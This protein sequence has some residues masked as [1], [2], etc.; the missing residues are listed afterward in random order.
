MA[1]ATVL[2]S[3]PT[4]I[5]ISPAGLVTSTTFLAGR[6][7]TE[8]DNTTPKFLDAN[9][10]GFVTTG[11]TPTVGK[12]IAIY[13]WGAH[14]SLATTARDVLDGLDSAETITSENVRAGFLKLAVAVQVDAASDRKYEFGP[15][16]V[17]AALGLATLPR[18]WGV[19]MAHDTVAALNATAGNHE[20]RF[21]GIKYDL[22]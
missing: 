19:F 5:T 12:T 21:V 9:L 20:M 10:Q 8:N 16:S 17:A 6:E 4:L 2:Y 1:V 3:A 22:T 11:T 18:Y 15:V 14:T 13:V 7:S